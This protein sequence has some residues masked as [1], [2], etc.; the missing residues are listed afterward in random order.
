[1]QQRIRV[2]SDLLPLK[3]EVQSWLK[4]SHGLFDYE[5]HKSGQMER[6]TLLA[7]D[8]ASFFVIRREQN[9]YCVA[10]EAR[11]NEY[12]DGEGST[13]LLKVLC[14][15]NKSGCKYLL[16]H[17]ESLTDADFCD[18]SHMMHFVLKDFSKAKLRRLKGRMSSVV[19][20]PRNFDSGIIQ[21]V[22]A[23]SSLT[24]QPRLDVHDE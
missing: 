23:D 12:E 9:C 16:Y 3:F 20:E 10:P 22:V 1:M 18:S 14:R 19:N 8:R 13:V 24:F 5:A 11:I 21:K 4:D 15:A 7:R 6:E 2:I 17:K